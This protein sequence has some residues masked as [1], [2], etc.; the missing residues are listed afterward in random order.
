[1]TQQHMPRSLS[2]IFL[3]GFPALHT[4]TQECF[5]DKDPPCIPVSIAIVPSHPYTFSAGKR[6][7]C[8]SDL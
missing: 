5:G 3:D 8:P 2:P 7:T 6:A 1:M 4:L